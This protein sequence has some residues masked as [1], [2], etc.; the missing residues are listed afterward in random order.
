M[1]LYHLGS[2]RRTI[3]T[4]TALRQRHLLWALQ[5]PLETRGVGDYRGNRSGI[6]HQRDATEQNRGED[7]NK[8]QTAQIGNGRAKGP[9]STQLYDRKM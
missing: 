7:Q 1:P 3:L 4:Y 6:K 9:I 5:Q 2:N 8:E